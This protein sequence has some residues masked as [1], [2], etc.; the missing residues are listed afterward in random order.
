MILSIYPCSHPRGCVL[1]KIDAAMNH[2]RAAQVKH[3]WAAPQSFGDNYYRVPSPKELKAIID[4]WRSEGVEGF[5]TYTWN[6]CGD[7]Q[8]LAK[9]SRALGHVEE[10]ERPLNRLYAGFTSCWQP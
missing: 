4:R 9:P 10:R 2:V 7:P 8:T 6:C 1:S 5:F 3:P